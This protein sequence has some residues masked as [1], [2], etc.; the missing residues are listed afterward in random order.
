ERPR[1][2]ELARAAKA[3]GVNLVEDLGGGL[4]VPRAA[5]QLDAALSAEP[6]AQACLAAGA[7]LVTFSLDKLFGGPQGGA[8][9]GAR[10]LVDRLRSD[11]L[12][13]AVPVD[14]LTIPPRAG[15]RLPPPVRVANL[16]IAPLEAV[17]GAY[18]RADYD[19]I[20]VLRQLRASVAS[21]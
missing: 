9:V 6:P 13:R 15:P 7:D 11:P 16:T 19:A 14:Q 3:N 17:L 2:S 8:A 5:E 4:V 20:P 18:G 10:A 1:A 12:A 21:L